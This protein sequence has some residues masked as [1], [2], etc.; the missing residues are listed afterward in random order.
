MPG[1]VSVDQNNIIKIFSVA[2]VVLCRDPDR[3]D[4]R[5]E[6]SRTCWNWPSSRISDRDRYGGGDAAHYF[7]LEEMAAAALQPSADH[8]Q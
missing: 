5:H 4:L 6:I 3:L 7:S 1:V 8:M 2:A